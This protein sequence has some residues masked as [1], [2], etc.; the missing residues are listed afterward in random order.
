MALKKEWTITTA[1]G[2]RHTINRKNSWALVDGE[3]QKMG[4]KSAFIQLYDHEIRI[5]GSVCH[6]VVIGRK[7]DLAVDG[8]FIESRQPYE[9]VGAVP[10]YAIV[11]S[12]I[13]CIVGFLMNKWLGLLIGALL[14]V[15]YC[16]FAL[17]KRPTAAILTFI[18]GVVCQIVFGFLLAFFLLSV[19]Y[20]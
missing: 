4:L 9:S 6:L 15:F 10:T 20:T 13:S 11:L 17:Q 3:K 7:C 1:D 12:I 2:S 8:V 18:V 16:S 19:L 5:G 14:S